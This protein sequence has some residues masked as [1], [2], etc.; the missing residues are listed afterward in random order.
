MD[1]PVLT[2]D[3]PALLLLAGGVALVL[4]GI[5]ALA[6][7]RRD[8][9][10]GEYVGADIAGASLTL[11]S[12]RWRLVG[13]PDLV[14]RL[15]DGR[16]IPIELKSRESP[17]DRPPFS[18]LVQVWAY[19]ALIEESTGHS[20]PYGVIRYGDGREWGVPWGPAERAELWRLRAEVGRPYDGR[21]SP[22]AGRCLRCRY[23]PICPDRFDRSGRRKLQ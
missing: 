20:P 17:A 1:L 5:G 7:R 23:R 10:F 2:G 13:R 6:R 4:G 16:R 9:R 14:R 18:H 19:C 3:L 11:R 21:S 15:P 12:E 22:S 8:R